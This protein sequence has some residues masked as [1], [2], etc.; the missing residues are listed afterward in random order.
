VRAQPGRWLSAVPADD[1]LPA[2]AAV[3]YE[4]RR[5]GGREPCDTG[6]REARML[7]VRRCEMPADGENA[8]LLRRT[9][10]RCHADRRSR[11]VPKSGAAAAGNPRRGVFHPRRCLVRGLSPRADEDFPRSPRARA[12]PGSR[13]RPFDE[14][15]RPGPRTRRSPNHSADSYKGARR[16]EDS[17]RASSPNIKILGKRFRIRTRPQPAARLAARAGRRPRRG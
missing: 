9:G 11:L 6:R 15:G 4:R 3:R 10:P 7:P 12:P 5:G 16:A 8:Q 2:E 13:E 17:R 14:H 1:P